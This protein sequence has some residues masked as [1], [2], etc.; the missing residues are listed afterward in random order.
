TGSTA[1]RNRFNIQPFQAFALM[2]LYG[3]KRDNGLFRFTKFYFDIGRK[4]GKTEFAALNANLRFCFMDMFQHQMY[5]AA[6]KKDQA[7]ITFNAAKI[8]LKQLAGE[9]KYFKKK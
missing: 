4:N 6:T 5:S 2:N 9:S 3:W 8:M 1:A 7:K